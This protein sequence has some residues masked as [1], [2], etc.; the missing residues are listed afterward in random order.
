MSTGA[1]RRREFE[2]IRRHIAGANEQANPEVFSLALKLATGAG[3]TTVMAMLIAWQ[4]V[5]AVRH[6]QRRQFTKNFLIVTPGITI[7]DRLRSLLPNDA[8]NYYEHRELVPNDMLGT[9]KQAQ[10]VITNFHAFRLR[11]R[12]A[13]PH[14]T[15]RL[16]Q[17]RTG[18]KLN[19]LETEGQMLR[20]V[21]PELMSKG[22]VLV[23]NDEGHHCYRERTDGEPVERELDAEEKPDAEKNNEYARVWISGVE[24]VKR[25]MGRPVLRDHPV[26]HRQGA[27]RSSRG[28]PVR[29]VFSTGVPVSAGSAGGD[30]AG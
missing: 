22:N 10:V 6:P 21:M 18:P 19:T 27:S 30:R 9:V 7:R 12:E 24:A 2:V 17:G 15:R 3:K 8:E 16:A 14:N 28:L 11:E 29:P 20:R 5:N 4:T 1:S 25:K 26:A 23:F 13:I